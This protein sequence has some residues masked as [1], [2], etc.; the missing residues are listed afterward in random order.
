[1][2]N[3]D[4]FRTATA[5]TGGITSGFIFGHNEIEAFARWA[6]DLERF[7]IL[8]LLEELNKEA[9]DRQHNYYGYAIN[10]I[11]EKHDTTNSIVFG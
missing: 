3:D 1:M 6:A 11:K 5:M 4:I 9:D 2:T 8:Q 7:R 10:R